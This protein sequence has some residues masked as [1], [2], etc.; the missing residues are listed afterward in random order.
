MPFPAP[1]CSGTGTNIMVP[2]YFPL[3]DVGCLLLPSVLFGASFPLYKLCNNETNPSWNEVCSLLQKDS[4]VLNFSLRKVFCIS[5]AY[6]SSMEFVIYHSRSL[7][8]I[9]CKQPAR[10]LSNLQVQ[11]IISPS[12]MNSVTNNSIA[13]RWNYGRYFD[14]HSMFIGFKLH[15]NST[16][17]QLNQVNCDTRVRLPAVEPTF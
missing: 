3:C 13:S 17:A 10:S 8:L 2:T 12:L 11:T 7:L 15:V 14:S 5:I 9:Q 1:H 6:R 4:L 16:V